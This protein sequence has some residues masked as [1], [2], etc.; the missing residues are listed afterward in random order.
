MSTNE[1]QTTSRRDF[2]KATAAASIGSLAAEPSA[3]AFVQDSRA[4]GA[5]SS[6]AKS[7]PLRMFEG[8]AAAAAL[9]QLRA[10]GV[11][12]IFHTN[13]SG[14]SPLFDAIYAA[15]DVQI[16]MVTHEGQGVATAAGYAMASK[17][18]GFFVGS[19][20]GIGN[21]ISNL[22][23]A[24]KDRVP[25]LVTFSHG[26][27]ESQ[28]KDAAESWDGNLRPTERFANWTGSLPTAAGTDILRRA[29]G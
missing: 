6:L 14:F 3:S 4:P 9:E 25:V 29:I 19:G 15:G 27:I 11:K 2:I 12:T 5:D 23:C 21:S 20:A 26:D 28:G 7:E 8:T 16:I 22:Y 17:S 1:K 13:T 18:L 10:A 24:W